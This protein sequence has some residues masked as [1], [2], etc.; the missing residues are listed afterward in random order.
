MIRPVLFGCAL[1]VALV[2]P[3]GAQT[4]FVAP[5][6]DAAI[7]SPLL[8]PAAQAAHPWSAL[9]LLILTRPAPAP[10]SLSFAF[11]PQAFIAAQ[12]AQT[13][14]VEVEAA[15]SIGTTPAAVAAAP[16]DP[17]PTAAI[18]QPVVLASVLDDIETEA[19]LVRAIA[20]SA[21][22]PDLKSQREAIAAVYENH[23]DRLLWRANGGWS[24]AA[25]AALAR[26]AAANEDALDLSRVTLPALSD[27]A[28][29]E[30][31]AQ[32]VALSQAV[33][34]YAREA[35]GSRIDPARI[36]RLITAKPEL[37]NARDVLTSV[38]AAGDAAGDVLASF[39]PPHPGYRALREKLA[40]LR[41]AAPAVAQDRIPAGPPLRVGMRDARVKLVRARFGMEI[42]QPESPDAVLYDTRV[43]EAVAGFQRAKGLPA[44]GI[45]TARTVALLSGGEPGRLE[46]EIVANMERWRWLP[47]DLGRDRVEVD[48]PN[49]TV[50]V[51][52]DGQVTHRARVVVGKPTN[53]TPIFS[54]TMKFAVVNPS[55]YIP[56]S[57][58]KK[59]ILPKLAADP[60]YL[61]RLGYEMTVRRGQ[62][63]VRQPPG[64]RN[65][66]GHI[67]FMFPNEH[68][69]YL[70][71]TPSRALFA[72]AKRAFSHGCVRV[73]DPMA[74]AQAVLGGPWTA[75]RVKSLVG[76]GE[77]TIN[78]AEPLPIHLEYFTASV[79]ADGRLALRDDI[80]GYDG[81][82]T[83]ALARE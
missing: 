6:G 48:I 58:L 62:V 29:A 52:R 59:E 33:V 64:E 19:A 46:N 31:A 73:D 70:H 26:L 43:A 14:P 56:P 42:S 20:A 2:A 65:A 13:A 57:I 77:R 72:S 83:R 66:L 55:W 28:P 54:N 69:V 23:P 53:P 25:R 11:D 3:A 45:L 74:F 41:R 79:G 12:L 7:E 36:S 4:G 24:P 9:A 34:A 22:T 18:P 16:V 40:E 71:D 17:A 47:R 78:L 44:S 10:S 35:A 50:A 81:A 1:F 32:D 75:A 80:Y 37:P 68:S 67:K 60:L 30:I 15:K 61:Q 82:V 39:N 76:R 51:L 38:L 8:D 63:S 5:A 27:G 49:Y 21:P